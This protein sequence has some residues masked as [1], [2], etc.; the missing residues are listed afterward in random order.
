MSNS[1]HFYIP[2]YVSDTLIIAVILVQHHIMETGR[3]F[4]Y[5][6]YS[7]VKT[8]NRNNLNFHHLSSILELNDVQYR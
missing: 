3:Y 6:L 8:I 2:V 4:S 5:S 7:I 1:Y